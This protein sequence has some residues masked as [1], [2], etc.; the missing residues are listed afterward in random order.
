MRTLKKITAVFLATGLLFN[1][2]GCPA[3]DEG[4]KVE[5]IPAIYKEFYNYPAGR[6]NANGLLTINNM[7]DSTALLFI[8]SVDSAN[9][10]GTV[11][12]QKSVKVKLA[13]EKLYV[14]IAVDKATYEE[15]TSQVSRY[16]TLVYY[17]NSESYQ[18][19]VFPAKISGNAQ[20][21]MNNYTAYWIQVK[22]P[23]LETTYAVIPPYAQNVSV[24]INYNEY[25]DYTPVYSRELKYNG[26][27]VALFEF[28]DDSQSGT[29]F[30]TENNPVYTSIFNNPVSEIKIQPTVIVINNSDR[31]LRAYYGSLLLTNGYDEFVIP[32][33]AQILLSGFNVGGN[34]NMINFFSIAWGTNKWVTQDIIMKANKV[35]QITIDSNGNSITVEELD[36]QD[37][38]D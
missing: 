29:V 1:L 7:A 31:V 22:T 38:F 34:T 8:N 2:A 32:S 33:D 5:E 15:K 23:D 4:N 28:N 6:V 37:V 14:I 13:D 3:D 17:S 19:S 36:A 16:M 12:A 18:V 10:I 9:Y 25:Y 35:Y 11:E 24:P 26:K 27:V 30:C 21:K 20:W